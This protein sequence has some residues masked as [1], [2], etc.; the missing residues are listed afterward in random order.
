[1]K[2]FRSIK[3][4]WREKDTAANQLVHDGSVDLTAQAR[5]LLF[6]E[7][8]KRPMGNLKHMQRS[9]VLVEESFGRT[10]QNSA[11]FPT[12]AKRK[13]LLKKSCLQFSMNHIKRIQ[14]SG[15][16]SSP[17]VW[18]KSNFLEYEPTNP[19]WCRVVTALCC[20]GKKTLQQE[21]DSW[22]K[23]EGNPGENL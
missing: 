14:Q 18:P 19:E 17:K 16:R 2:P 9:T 3:W 1:M 5:R 6:R 15:R 23:V 10:I 20:G 22:F 13:T 4:R 12:L 11:T 21:D 7:A 8:A